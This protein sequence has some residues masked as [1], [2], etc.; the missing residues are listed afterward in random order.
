RAREGR[1]VAA[2]ARA[3]RVALARL[4]PERA[5]PHHR[6]EAPRARRLGA[7][8]VRRAADL[9]GGLG[10]PAP[11]TALALPG[12]LRGAAAARRA[13][14][15]VAR[16]RRPRAELVRDFPRPRPALELLG[17]A[18][19]PACPRRADRVRP[20]GSARASAADRPDGALH[21]VPAGQLHRAVL[22]RA[23]G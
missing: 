13:E 22:V 23:P 17:R 9:G 11:R 3:A 15:T 19:A 7:A 20:A 18:G 12:P 2:R 8:P 4:L 21:G 5:L 16:R 14:G 10:R 6:P 1:G